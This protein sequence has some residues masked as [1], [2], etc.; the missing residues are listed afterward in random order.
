MIKS[1][2]I[3]IPYFIRNHVHIAE[4]RSTNSIRKKKY[5]KWESA[6]SLECFTQINIDR[7]SKLQKKDKDK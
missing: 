4:T 2:P 5:V 1:Y 7:E 3:D 6:P